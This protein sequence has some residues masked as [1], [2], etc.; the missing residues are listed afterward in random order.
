VL[1]GDLLGGLSQ[2]E[3]HVTS[4]FPESE[5]LR[6]K[7]VGDS[8]V[9]ERFRATFRETLEE[10]RHSLGVSDADRFGEEVGVLVGTKRKEGE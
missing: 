2:V 10:R 5:E 9:V 8:Q 7:T 6:S 3:G 4:S 1:S